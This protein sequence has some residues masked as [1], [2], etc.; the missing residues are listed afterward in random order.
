MEEIREWGLRLEE[1]QDYQSKDDIYQD[2]LHEVQSE[3]TPDGGKSLGAQLLAKNVLT[4]PHYEEITIDVLISMGQAAEPKQSQ[5]V[6]IHAILGLVTYVKAQT[7]ISLTIHEKLVRFVQTTIG[8]E[9]SGVL[10]RHLTSLQKL[11]N[12]PVNPTVAALASTPR[13]HTPSSPIADGN[14]TGPKREEIPPSPFLFIKGFT[15]ST[16]LNRLISY[17]QNVDPSISRQNIHFHAPNKSHNQNA[18]LNCLTIEKARAAIEYA[19]THLFYGRRLLTLFARGPSVTSVVFHLAESFP[20]SW[21]DH[22]DIWSQIQLELQNRYPSGSFTVKAVGKVTFESLEVVKALVVQGMQI[23]EHKIWIVYDV[24]EQNKP[25]VRDTRDSASTL[26]SNTTS[27]SMNNNALDP[28]FVDRFM[29]RPDPPSRFESNEVRSTPPRQQVHEPSAPSRVE[30]APQE[31]PPRPARWQPEPSRVEPA[32]P[33]VP[34]PRPSSWQSYDSSKD[35]QDSNQRPYR[36]HSPARHEE[37]SSKRIHDAAPP[38]K[39]SDSAGWVDDRQRK[40]QPRSETWTREAPRSDRRGQ[41]STSRWG[42]PKDTSS[43]ADKRL[44]R[45]DSETTSN[46][47]GTDDKRYEPQGAR[48]VGDIAR[49]GGSDTRRGRSSEKSYPSRSDRSRERPQ[50]PPQLNHRPSLGEIARA[51]GSDKYNDQLKQQQR[52][53][54]GS[55]YRNRP[56]DSYRHNDSRREP[57]RTLPSSRQGRS[58]SRSRSREKPRQRSNERPLSIGE[59]ARAGGSDRFRQ[60][61]PKYDSDDNRSHRPVPLTSLSIGEIARAGGGSLQPRANRSSSRGRDTRDN[62]AKPGRSDDNGRRPA[63]KQDYRSS[64]NRGRPAERRPASRSAE[65]RHT[66][67]NS[68]RWDDR[69]KSD[70]SWKRDTFDHDDRGVSVGQLARAKRKDYG[71]H[72]DRGDSQ[73]RRQSDKEDFYSGRTQV[74]YSGAIFRDEEQHDDRRHSEQVSSRRSPTPHSSPVSKPA[75]SPRR[76]PTPEKRVNPT[77]HAQFEVDECEVDYDEDD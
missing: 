52:G 22:G 66:A 2:I 77:R 48:S 70:S 74:D 1:E 29:R 47:R 26:V 59:I 49:L 55:D 68:T 63:P 17:F 31:M 37:S 71:Q 45:R 13:Q 72:D 6:R 75:S 65:R 25:R 28:A 20:T 12:P 24:D 3:E 34:P 8:R 33:E 57:E 38:S 62:R 46:H 35:R 27:I 56:D 40:D 36:G 64:D 5:S 73:R 61:E 76:D 7:T 41:E 60:N 43:R 30:S 11:L 58:R 53:G 54:S 23:Q 69:R 44:D 39:R 16:D 32:L 10:V 15:Q 18:F 9:T 4:F 42:E 21:N 67:E 14:D 19:K 51:G 50:N